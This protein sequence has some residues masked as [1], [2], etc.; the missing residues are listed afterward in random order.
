M[1]YDRSWIDRRF[2]NG[3]LNEEYLNGIEVFVTFAKS[4][5][6]CLPD[7]T[8]RCPCNHKKCQNL[9]YWDENTVKV[10]L[11]R[12]EFVPNYYKW[13]LYGENYIRPSFQGINMEAPSSS[14]SNRRMSTDDMTPNFAT[15][16]N[17][18]SYSD[19]EYQFGG[20]QTY[21]DY[22]NVIDEAIMN[23]DPDTNVVEDPHVNVNEEDPNMISRALYD[24]IKSTEKDIWEGNPYGHTLLSVLARLL[25]MK[26]QH[27]MSERNYNDMCQLMTELCPADHY[28]PKKF[29]A[30][31]KL[32]KYMGLPVDK[33]DCCNNN[34][35]IYWGTESE[36]TTCRFCE[37]P[38][39]KQSRSRG[40]RK[41]MKQI[42]YKRMYYFPLTPRL[43]RLYASEATT[44]HMRWHHE[45]V[46][47]GEMMTYPSNS[48]AWRNFT[49]T[50]PTFASEIRNVN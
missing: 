43:Q 29:N 3:S 11:C 22:P 5:P 19:S 24:M 12:Y 6:T 15:L 34:C 42:A 14:R 16:T 4:N 31:K 20:D 48:P 37:H 45:H 39:Y 33:I 25:K 7:E 18:N 17:P 47:D 9:S 32:V 30:T 8:I 38:R 40:S 21:Y 36:L 44:S 28:F 35:M 1:A 46:Y 26:Y 2:V 41:N 50:H 13:Y 10:H 49:E 23:E 27:S